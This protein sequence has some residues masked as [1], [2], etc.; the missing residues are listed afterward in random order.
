MK[1]KQVLIFCVLGVIAF[2]IIKMV[3][4]V[5]Q[6]SA[7]YPPMK[8]YNLSLNTDE[9]VNK[10]SNVGKNDINLNFKITDTTGTSKNGFKY[11]ADVYL[12]N[13]KDSYTFNLFYNKSDKEHSKIGLVGAFDNSH[14]FGG[15]QN[16]GKDMQILINI[17]ERKFIDRINDSP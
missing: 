6:I 11:Y 10:M 9:L 2:Y 8:E 14:K 3:Y 7:V 5:L 4:S 1:W 13:N 17:F 12:K 15:Y 16:N